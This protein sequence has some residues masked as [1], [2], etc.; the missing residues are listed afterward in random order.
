MEIILVSYEDRIASGFKGHQF[1]MK[2][3]QEYTEMS[4]KEF[5][6]KTVQSTVREHYI[7]TRS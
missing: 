6:F 1:K 5:S 7:C 3:W 2:S 4:F